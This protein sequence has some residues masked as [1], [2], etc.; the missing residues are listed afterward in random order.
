M[1]FTRIFSMSRFFPFF[2]SPKTLSVVPSEK[3]LVLKEK[4]NENN[5]SKAVGNPWL[6]HKE[7]TTYCKT[8]RCRPTRD[9]CRSSYRVTII[10]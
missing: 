5:V 7:L 8:H 4:K 9:P 1:E 6:C 2:L 10:P 3:Y